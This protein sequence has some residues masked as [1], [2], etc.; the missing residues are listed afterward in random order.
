MDQKLTWIALAFIVVAILCVLC[1]VYYWERKK[2]ADAQELEEL[3]E[4]AR[5]HLE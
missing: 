4:L 1:S 5:E 2:I 3:E